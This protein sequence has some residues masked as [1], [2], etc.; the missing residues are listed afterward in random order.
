LRFGLVRTLVSE[1]RLALRL[2]REPRV[3]RLIKGLPLL[4]LVYLV[5]PIDVVPDIVLLLGQ[6]DDVGF[7]VL[8]LQAFRRLCPS[9]VVEFHRSAVAEGRRYS[10]MSTADEVI[11]VEWKRV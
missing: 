7:L 1:V 8:A 9:A 6:L 5:S 4:A 2:L 3:P 11:D 10:A